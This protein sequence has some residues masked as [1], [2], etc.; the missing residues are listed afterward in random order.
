VSADH[1]CSDEAAP[2]RL[3]NLADGHEPGIYSVVV[4]ACA[5]VK[6]KRVKDRSRSMLRDSPPSI[7]NG[8]EQI[9]LN[10]VHRQADPSAVVCARRRIGEKVHDNLPE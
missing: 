8:Q 1:H 5:R 3:D 6:N 7:D 10:S 2:L 4:D 9:A